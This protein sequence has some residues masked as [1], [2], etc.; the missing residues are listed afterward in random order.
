[1]Q[2]LALGG[3]LHLAVSLGSVF[4]FVSLMCQLPRNV[5]LID[6]QMVWSNR[7]GT[8]PTGTLTFITRILNHAQNLFFLIHTIH[9]FI[10]PSVCLVVFVF[11]RYAVG[12]VG[13]VVWVEAALMG[14]VLWWLL[15]PVEFPTWM[16]ADVGMGR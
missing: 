9:Q 13:L 1:L 11:Y 3:L 12:L 10:Y 7:T 14:L 8:K 6:R 4:K 5:P 15:A 16:D 2:L